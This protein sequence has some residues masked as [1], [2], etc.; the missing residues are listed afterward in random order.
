M[1][2]DNIAAQDG[3]VP[4]V[5]LFSYLRPRVQQPPV[6]LIHEAESFTNYIFHRAASTRG[7]LELMIR[8]SSGLSSTLSKPYL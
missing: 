3:F 1:T 4:D 8:S 5:D 7:N 6:A 2:V